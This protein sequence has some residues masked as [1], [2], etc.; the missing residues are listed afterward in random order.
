MKKKIRILHLED[1]PFD[2][3]IIKN[4]IKGSTDFESEIICVSTKNDFVK[5]LKNSSI[6]HILRKGK[7]L[8][9]ELKKRKKY[10][11]VH[12][13][14]TGQLIYRDKKE[15]ENLDITFANDDQE[16]REINLYNDRLYFTQSRRERREKII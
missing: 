8:I 15:I 13:R 11:L 2:Q 1:D 4:I 12:L 5:E 16:V 9:F 14:M 3:E 6:K 7:L 10:L